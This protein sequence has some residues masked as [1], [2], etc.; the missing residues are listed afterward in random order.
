MRIT[1]RAVSLTSLQGLNRNLDSLGRLQQQLSSGKLLNTPSDS[2]T[3]TNRSMQ[4]RADQA[5]A[6]QQARNIS[7]AESWL[8]ATDSV[9][10]T[11][12]EATRRVRELAV[13][14]SNT[15]SMSPVARQ[16]IATEVETLRATLVGQANQSLQGRPLFGGI[17][18][19]TTAYDPTGGWIGQ[20][21][22]G[23]TR[24]V[25]DTE[26][27]R[28]DVSGP[29]AFGPPGNDLF[30]VVGRI[31]ADMAANPAALAGHLTDLDSAVD[32]MLTAVADIGARARRV[33]LA[34][35]INSER[36]LT[37]QGRL[38]QTEDIDL[39]Y[40]IMRMQMQKTGYEAALSATAKSIQPSLVDFLR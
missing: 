21:G 26:Q 4:T 30:A 11:M 2:P 18:A 38:A 5:A 35:R 24:L 31:A 7:D 14:G 25:S 15:G 23:I 20:S 17:T 16:A 22:P 32:G 29:E 6:D 37:L 3:G 9:L 40:T 8:N 33:E 10:Q 27:V 39:P 12:I 13:Q 34:G 1:Q 36:T 28:V 19:G